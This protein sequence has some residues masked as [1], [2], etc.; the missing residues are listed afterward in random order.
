MSRTHGTQPIS[1]DSMP[2]AGLRVCLLPLS[3]Y[4]YIYISVFICLLP[5]FPFIALKGSSCDVLPALLKP[6]GFFNRSLFIWAL[7]PTHV[8]HFRMYLLFTIIC[9]DMAYV[10]AK[11]GCLAPVLTTTFLII[12][13]GGKGSTSAIVTAGSAGRVPQTG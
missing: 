6:G 13:L 7:C 11:L 8:S 9:I 4:I 10:L 1:E 3:I 5:L 2:S 12:R